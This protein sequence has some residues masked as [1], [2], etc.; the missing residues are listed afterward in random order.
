MYQSA[1]GHLS[2]DECNFEGGLAVSPG[3]HRAI[4]RVVVLALSLGVTAWV[5]A[6]PA[7]AAITVTPAQ[8]WGTNGRVNAIL[9]L[10]GNV[11]LGGTF[12]Q[13]VDPAGH[14]FPASNLAVMDPTGRLSA[15]EGKGAGG[16]V[17]GT[18]ATVRALAAQGNR[19]LLGGDFTAVNGAPRSHLAAMSLT[20]DL[21][22]TWAPSADLSVDAIVATPSTAY[23]GGSFTSIGGSAANAFA[24]KLDGPAAAVDTAWAPAPS[25]RVRAMVLSGTTLY[26]GGDFT[27]VGAT[28]SAQTAAVAAGGTGT[29]VP[30]Y[31][32]AAGPATSFVMSLDTDGTRVYAGVGGPGG[33]FCT[34]LDGAT[35]LQLWSKATNGDVQAVHVFDGL[36]YCGGHF[37]G[38]AT[39]PSFDGLLRD[40]LAAVQPDGTTT[41]FNPTVNSALGIYAM[42]SSAGHLYIGGD[43]TKVEGVATQHFADFFDAAVQQ[44]PLA[45]ALVSATAG[46]GVVH[47]AWDPP[48]SDGGSSIDFYLVFKHEAGKPYPLKGIQVPSPARVYDDTTVV[49][50]TTYTYQVKAHN[51]VPNILTRPWPA[52]NELS[53][54]PAVGA[55]DAPTA[56]QATAGDGSATVSWTAPASDGGAAIT[57]YTVTS[58]PPGGSATV[59][60]PATTAAVTGLSNGTAYTFTVTA[61]NSLGTSVSSAP[62]AAVT[63]A[64]PAPPPPPPAPVDSTAPTPVLTSAPAANSNT[65]IATVSFTA[66]DPDDDPATLKFRC[67][68]DAGAAARCAS[69]LVLS[70]LAEG[71][72]TVTIRALDPAGNGSTPVAATWRVDVTAPL[73][74]SS[75]PRAPLT[76]ASTVPVA[77]TGADIGT[78]IANFDVRY[79]RSAWNAGFTAWRYPST[80]QHTTRLSLAAAVPAGYTDC[81]S[82]RARDA[83]GNVSAWTTMRCSAR[84]LDDR[85]LSAGK[86]W[87]RKKSKVSTGPHGYYGKTYTATTH[88]GA[89]L[90]RTAVQTSRLAL[91][92]TRCRTCGT[93]GVY[94]NGKLL[95]KVSLSAKTTQHRALVNLP[96]FSL[97]KT[98]VTIKVLSS[99]KAVQ[100][101]GLATSRR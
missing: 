54:T 63:P 23:V 21:D 25:G 27:S 24:A 18:N 77:W 50:G 22:A 79:A 57:G 91:V 28:T 80:W 55:P 66:T 95:H 32:G 90:T 74:A 38:N 99:G 75:A 47:L 64:A 34:A 48:S 58:S 35:G 8:Q 12:D 10:N 6:M 39:I 14:T 29:P 11:Y 83:A 62:S 84:A 96:R 7:V 37:S 72:H 100:I 56:V 4:A 49:N 101:D 19:I 5:A 93:V 43:F 17:G 2:S 40:K 78:G 51:R 13:I 3:H 82:M 30:G 88:A 15:F 41:A 42:S 60:A 92:A 45:P 76:T 31:A 46:N 1:P 36:A 61:T 94:L 16:G 81:F 68:V 20:G 71:V 33:G 87:T 59:T 67:T 70:D 52:S 98:T 85:A 53:A 89:T 44:P 26:L 73:A 97:R 65:R 86:G 9:P 69:P